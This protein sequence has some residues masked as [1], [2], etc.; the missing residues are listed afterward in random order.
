MENCMQTT[1][2]TMPARWA[3]LRVA[4]IGFWYT[5]RDGLAFLALIVAVAASALLARAW[6]TLTK[7]AEPLPVVLVAT[8]T[9]PALP[10]TPA[11][12]AVAS[13]PTLSRAVAAFAEPN[14]ALLGDAPA[15]SAYTVV[16]RNMEGWTL[17][18][19]A[20]IGGYDGAGLVW[21]TPSDSPPEAAQAPIVATAVPAPPPQIIIVEQQPAPAP[22]PAPQPEYRQSNADLPVIVPDPDNGRPCGADEYGQPKCAKRN[23]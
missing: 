8:I 13:V 20:G 10:A 16:Y 14:G 18:Q 23:P 9:L 22:A 4:A 2:L 7:A 6:P 3:A 19:V 21:V 15:G 12:I 5:H 17:L 1:P 11:P